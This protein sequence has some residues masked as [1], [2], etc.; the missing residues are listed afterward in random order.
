MISEDRASISGEISQALEPSDSC[1]PVLH[2]CC[3]PAT[4][5]FFVFVSE[6]PR[7]GRGVLIIDPFHIYIREADRCL[8][9]Q[10]NIWKEEFC[11]KTDGIQSVT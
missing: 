1:F 2:T 11:L 4:Q 9:L 5:V 8:V 10:M 7:L 3:I 6:S